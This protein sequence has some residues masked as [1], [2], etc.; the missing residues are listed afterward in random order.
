V[1]TEYAAAPSHLE[2]LTYPRLCALADGAWSGPTTWSD[3]TARLEGHTA[4]L[5]VLEVSRRP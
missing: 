4:R 2:Y 1:W 5:D 3:F